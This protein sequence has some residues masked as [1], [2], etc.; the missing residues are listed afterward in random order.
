M[1]DKKNQKTSLARRSGRDCL[2]ELFAIL[3][4][5]DQ[6][7]PEPD[8]SEAQDNE[9]GVTRAVLLPERGGRPVGGVPPDDW[10]AA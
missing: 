9:G 4:D 5:P 1:G 2:R 3:T 10:E 8:P 7:P 6:T